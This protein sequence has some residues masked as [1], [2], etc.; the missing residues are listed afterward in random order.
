[1]MM[2]AVV[3]AV[4][5]SIRVRR[6]AM[7]ATVF[8]A[9]AV[10]AAIIVA[11][12]LLIVRWAAVAVIIAVLAVVGSVSVCVRQGRCHNTQSSDEEKSFFHHL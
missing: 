2:A 6:A 9:T 5:L 12:G 10:A 11:A 3:L 7:R 8:T 1:M 4:I